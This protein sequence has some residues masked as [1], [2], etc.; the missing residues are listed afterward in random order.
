VKKIVLF[1]LIMFSVV[2][3]SCKGQNKVKLDPVDMPTLADSSSYLYEKGQLLTY[4]L[5][6]IEEYDEKI[7]NED[8]FLLLVYR[9]GC[10]GCGLIAPAL[11]KYVGEKQIPVFALSL[12][13]VSSKHDL[14]KSGITDTPYLLVIGDGK[15]VYKEIAVLTNDASENEKWVEKWMNKHVDWSG[16]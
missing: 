12:E 13:L 10:Y 16:K 1:I 15:V 7:T 8:S 6:A 3:C 14:Y 11:Q 9:D 5:K 4:D 2:G